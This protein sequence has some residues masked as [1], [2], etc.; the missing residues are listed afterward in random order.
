MNPQLKGELFSLFLVSVA[1]VF[2]GF[3]IAPLLGKLLTSL[4]NN[5][6]SGKKDFDQ[7][8]DQMVKDKSRNMG[9]NN[10][11]VSRKPIHHSSNSRASK[12]K[13]S[14]SPA[15]L[16]YQRLPQ[17]LKNYQGDDKEHYQS[18]LENNLPLSDCFPL[19]QALGPSNPKKDLGLLQN[20]IE[21]PFLTELPKFQVLCAQTELAFFIELI[22]HELIIGEHS[23]T[24]AEASTL[25][26]IQVNQ[27]VF[28]FKVLSAKGLPEKVLFKQWQ[29]Q[30][31]GSTF[32]KTLHREN[33][34]Y[35]ATLL[36]KKG[37]WNYTH[38]EA[39]IQEL[40]TLSVFFQSLKKLSSKKSAYPTQKEWAMEILEL[41]NLDG[42]S[43]KSQYKKMVKSTHPD[44]ISQLSQALRGHKDFENMANENF[45]QVKQAYEYLKKIA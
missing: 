11:T 25:Y 39:F 7:S 20:F 37:R 2:A 40:R 31:I 5:Y 18:L 42:K 19:L 29:S 13:S 30:N 43:L 6:F 36:I 23:Q 22:V 8:F 21:K 1:L 4:I 15:Q 41:E 9:K 26:D 12:K 45:D 35:L 32:K 10:L 3:K 24:L 38:A 34:H 17:L 14:H 28:L 27:S 44:T 16:T 33:G